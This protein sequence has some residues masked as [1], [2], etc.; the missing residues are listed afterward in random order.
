MCTS[1]TNDALRD[2][3][4]VCLIAQCLLQSVDGSVCGPHTAGVRSNI[5]RQQRRTQVLCSLYY[6]WYRVPY[7]SGSSI[8]YFQSR[9]SK[10]SSSLRPLCHFTVKHIVIS[11][12]MQ[13]TA[14]AQSRA[15]S[16]PRPVC[17]RAH[18]RARMWALLCVRYVT[19]LTGRGVSRTPHQRR[20]FRAASLLTATEAGT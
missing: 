2:A 9:S 11:R 10:K 16:R 17:V 15:V 6:Q 14:L 19:Y 5:N 4:R 8:P 18:V 12:R 13:F 1:A 7:I 3:M 20:V